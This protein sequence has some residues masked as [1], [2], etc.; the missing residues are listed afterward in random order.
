MD[1]QT[2]P[3]M[4]SP[5]WIYF[6]LFVLSA[7]MLS[8]EVVSTR[9]ASVVFVQDYAFIVLSLAILGLGSGGIASYYSI[10]PRDDQFRAVFRSLIAVGISLAFFMVA[11]IEFAV[12][13]PF[14]YFF[15]LF[16]PFFFGGIVYAQIYKLYSLLSYK[17][18][19]SDLSG[20]AVGSLASLALLN[21]LGRPNSVV[22]L[23]VVICWL[24][25]RFT[26]V[27]KRTNAAVIFSSLVVLLL[28]VLIANGKREF[29][30]RVPIGEFPEK[31]FYHVYPDPSIRSEIIDSRWSMYGRA[32]LVQY[33]HQDM[34]KQLFIDGS[35]GTQ[36]YRFNG[37]IRRT[38]SILQELL[39]QHTNSIPF[40]CMKENEKRSMLVIGPGG[41]KEVLIG[42]F[43]EVQKIVGVEVNSDFVQIV[44][45]YRTFDGGI[46]TDFSN[47]NIVVEEG[48]HYV[49]QT[50]DTFDLVVMALPSTEQMQNIEPF[51]MSENYLLT[52]EAIQDYMRILTP[53]G[54]LIFT[55]HNSWELTRMMITA[56][57]VLRDLGVR[58]QE[59]QNHFIAL[60]TEYAPTVVIKR[61]AF[62]TEETL[63]WQNTSKALP[64]G[65]PVVTYL[66]YGMMNGSQS[67]AVRFLTKVSQSDDAL[68]K[69]IAAN[70]TDVSP[71]KDDKPYFYKVF[72]GVPE[73][74]AWL[75]AAV[76][77]ACLVIIWLPFKFIRKKETQDSLP[78]VV[79]PMAIMACTGVG[80]MVVEISLFQKLVLFLGSP[81][82]SLA[83]LLSSLLVGMGIGSYCGQKIVGADV[84]KRIVVASLS[85][86]VTGSI[87]IVA[88]PVLLARCL[89]YSL[90]VR[91]VVSFL[92]ILPPAFS[93]G[94]PYPSCIQM[95]KSAGKEQYI[96]WL[97]GVNG[98]MSVLGSVLAVVL[99]MLVGFTLTYVAGLLF[100]LAV[101]CLMF[102]KNVRG[103]LAPVGQ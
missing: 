35:A 66:P 3:R 52:K 67:P 31:D 48:R 28:G 74:Y 18:Y 45:D 16:L 42:L 20:A 34:V 81:T 83:I 91:S 65:L 53:E 73:E 44:K 21:A 64:Q 49:R 9:I 68:Q 100:Y 96:P 10:K 6:S 57:S 103:T 15:L 33:S 59:L 51:A 13:N 36:V 8:F 61:N 29:L 32:D 86:I 94:I 80:F 72:R 102:L 84:W 93:L 40:V 78:K 47:V 70:A 85:I 5:R 90:V 50:K 27:A 39:L 2:V 95:A 25:M 24:S 54:K 4:N 63:Q 75:F 101:L 19:A 97:Y 12:V 69:Y 99:S 14:I 22:L 37:N 56:M 38:N 58:T 30:G 17:L 7:S 46:Y 82:I 71:C 76:A 11:V 41:G 87:F 98:A 92:M 60:E 55:V 77:G 1:V 88:A 89:E 23:A 26:Q 43:G 62:T 79:I